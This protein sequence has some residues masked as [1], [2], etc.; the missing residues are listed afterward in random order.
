MGKKN[1]IIN[2]FMNWLSCF[3]FAVPAL[4]F[5]IIFVIIP[6]FGTIN[7]SF[8]SWNGASPKMTFVGLA[9]YVELFKTSAFWF[10][11]K[12][13]I[14][15]ILFTIF[16]PVMLGLILATLV[17][18][19]YVRAK[20]LFRLI[21]FMPGIVSLVAVGIVWG[22][23]YHPAY[24]ILGRI[25]SFIG[26]PGARNIDFLG[27]PNLV[28]WY[29]VIAGSWTAFGF[30]MTIFLAAIQAIDPDFLEIAILEGANYLQTF[31]WVILPTIKGTVTLLV[32]NSLI[33]SFKVFDIIW[34]M[35]KGGPYNSSDVIATY[36]F[37]SSFN[38]NRYGYG[39][40]MA[41]VLTI[42]IAIFSII[43][44][45]LREKEN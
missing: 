20:L 42:I 14:I 40:A 44:M 28:I 3:A 24:G 16:V 31:F 27:N 39:S 9:N 1:R 41:V 37:R 13:N 15:W 23:I 22:W 4:F 21:Y 12:N 7:I 32:L 36:M 25:L 18:R 5:F 8:H 2:N 33:G 11:F 43:Y 30:N 17:S 35:T 29:L 10:S 26:I 6:L 45:R 19:P 38:L 34:I